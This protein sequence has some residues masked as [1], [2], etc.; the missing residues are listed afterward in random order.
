MG[1][2]IIAAS[3]MAAVD[4]YSAYSSS[5]AEK[6]KAS[7]AQAASQAEQANNTALLNEQKA[8]ALADETKQKNAQQL[9]S[10]AALNTT[11]TEVGG[12]AAASEEAGYSGSE[13]RRR[14][15]NATT[16]SGT[17]GL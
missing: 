14:K 12:S 13:I 3:I 15:R 6:K 1:Q 4:L 7:A 5:K 10:Q 2:Q 11:Q 17:L 16:I 8:Q 9:E